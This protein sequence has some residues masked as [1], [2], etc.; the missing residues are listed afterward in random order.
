ML[1]SAPNAFIKCSAD[2]LIFLSRFEQG[3]MGAPPAFPRQP[4]WKANDNTNSDFKDAH[5]L[6]NMTGRAQDEAYVKGILKERMQKSEA[7]LVLL[8]SNTKNLYKFVRW[9]IELAK[10][11]DL[12]II[13]ANLNEHI[14]QDGVLCPALIR[15]HCAVHVPYKM[16]AIQNAL[17]LYPSEYRRFD[18]QTKAGGWRSYSAETLKNWGMR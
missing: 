10:A 15:D 6:D 16:V 3:I 1:A 7:V 11:L 5:D 9:E 4:G 14:G 12:P 13:V 18:G 8:G 17:A 2:S